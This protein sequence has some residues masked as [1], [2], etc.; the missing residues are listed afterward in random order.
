MV[1][2]DIDFDTLV[3]KDGATLEQDARV[4]GESHSIIE[5]ETMIIQQT[6]SIDQ[7]RQ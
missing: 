4:R 3:E 7:K 1:M 5:E 2:K 6:E